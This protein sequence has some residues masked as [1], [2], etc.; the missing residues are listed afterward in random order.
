M[1]I[2]LLDRD[3]VINQ[4]N[5][6]YIKSVQEWQ[7]IQGSIQAI[8]DLYRAGFTIFIIT[9]QSGLA[10]GL[11]NIAT[12]DAMHA[13]MNNLVVAAG[14][15]IEKIYYCPHHPDDKCCCRKPDINLLL[16]LQKDY[17]IVKFTNT[18]FV[19]DTI[20]DIGAAKNIGAIPI[21]VQT[22][23]GTKTQATH[24][25]TDII[26]SNNLLAASKIII[27]NIA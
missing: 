8:A 17:P 18:Y 23:K 24:D 27:N 20:K 6:D 11:F 9:N 25:L 19:G 3:G 22:G 7:T 14:G 5:K 13:K 21:L 2:V 10:R 4:D 26:I 16:Q 12:L 15:E 1:K